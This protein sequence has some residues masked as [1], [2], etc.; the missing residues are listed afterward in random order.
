MKHL[1][2]SSLQHDET[3]IENERNT[4]NYRIFINTETE[5]KKFTR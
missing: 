5:L 4:M 1:I 3:K 2:V